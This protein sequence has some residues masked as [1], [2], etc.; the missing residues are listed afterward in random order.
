PELRPAVVVCPA[1]LKSNWLIEA[2][3]WLETDERIVVVNSGKTKSL[4]AD[5]I[6]INY[7]LM[8]KWVQALQSIRPKIL[9]A[10]ESHMLK[11][12]AAARSKAVKELASVTPHKI[13]LTGTP[14]LSRPGELW[15][16]LQILDPAQYPD[17]R[18]V[19]WHIRYAGAYKGRFGWDFSGASNL[20]ELAASLKTIMI[21][22]TKEQVLPELPAKRRQTL[23]VSINNRR[24]YNKADK[25]F[26]A[27]LIE[28]KG[29]EAAD[30]ASHVEQLAKIEYLRQIAI[31]GKMKQVQDSIKTFL[32]NGEKLV[33][34]A[35]HRATIDTL[36]SEFGGQAVKIVGGMSG[37]QKQ[38]SI[39]AFQND[40]DV[41]LFIGNIKAAGV[42]IT[43]TAASNVAFLELPWT[44]SDLEQAEDRLHRIGQ[45]NAVNVCFFLAE[46]TIDATIAT[47]LDTK[48][49]II[50]QIMS[51]PAG[52]GLNLLDLLQEAILDDNNK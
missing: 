21:R 22:R 19:A 31:R 10:D 17:S 46:G 43:L 49:S 52:A 25:E 13:F 26:M 28:Q 33:V 41:R 48:G 37:K 42:G 14:V 44:P 35:T 29:A 32:L 8:K 50:D 20:D 51:N 39:D 30:R 12:P 45:S 38:E 9:V 47:M 24:E 1:T 16:Q 36:M 2:R 3:A 15:N 5:I 18:F 27:W 34:F 4:D 40:P 6:I 7:E 11:T 23:L